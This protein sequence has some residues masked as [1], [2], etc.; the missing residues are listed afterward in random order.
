MTANE[1]LAIL[2]SAVSTIMAQTGM[3]VDVQAAFQP[4]NQGTQVAPFIAIHYVSSRRYGFPQVVETYNAS[5][6]SFDRV[7]SYILEETY[8]FTA[9]AMA[10]PANTTPPTA[11]D[12]AKRAA[13]VLQSAQLRGILLKYGIGFQRVTDIRTPFFIDDRERQEMSPSFDFTITREETVNY[14]VPVVV[15]TE[16]DIHRV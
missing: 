2:I 3:P 14:S 1:T 4:T 8:Q 10:D 9:Y 5:T 6:T 13:A 15:D 7:E 12:Y 16:I 11:Y